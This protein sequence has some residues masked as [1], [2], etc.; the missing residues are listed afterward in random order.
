MI[1]FR[2][3][4]PVLAIVV[5][6]GTGTAA[7]AS[8]RLQSVAGRVFFYGDIGSAVNSPYQ[9]N[10]LLVRPRTIYLTE[11]GSVALTDLRWSDWGSSVAR[12]VGLWSAS[13]CTPNCASGK[14]TTMTAHFTLSSPARLF[15]HRVYRCFSLHVSNQPRADVRECLE[16]QDGLYIYTPAP[17]PT[18]LKLRSGG[19]IVVGRF[20]CEHSHHRP[21][22]TVMWPRRG[23]IINGSNIQELPSPQ[24]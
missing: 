9:R 2:Y 16:P 11:D 6:C 24:T 7:A 18:A 12:A 8:P 15:G 17:A 20:R 10:P 3:A 1:S 22:C 13:N 5:T 19:R 23:F 4:V 21:I 14:R